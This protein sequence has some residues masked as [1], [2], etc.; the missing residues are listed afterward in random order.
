M[1]FNFRI[2][3]I[4]GVA[5]CAVATPAF[6]A[7]ASKP[8]PLADQ[9]SSEA[10]RA[11]SANDKQSPTAA[12]PGIAEGSD[13]VVTATLANEAAPVTASLK[14]TQPQSIISRS[15]IEE[16]LPAL[17]D[18]NQIALISP[19]FTNSGGTNGVGLSESKGQLR[20]FQDAEYNITYDGVP[21]GDTNDPSHHSNTFF[22]SNTIET[23]VVNRGP[24]NASNLGQATFGGSVDLFSRA[25]RQQR[26][27]EG[28]AT[29]GSFNTYLVRALG[30]SG[31]IDA[32]GGTEIVLS[33]Q[34]IN[35]DGARSL[36]PYT[37]SNVFGKIFIPISNDVKLSILG[38]YSYNRFRQP[39]ND[40]ITIA[41]FTTFGKTFSLNNDPNSQ[42]YTFYNPE[43]KK[44]DFE[45]VKLEAN[46]AP[47]S[48]FENRGYTYA[49]ENETL[50]G[51]TPTL[52]G[53]PTEQ[54][55]N[56][57]RLTPAGGLVFGVPGYT[58]TNLYRVWGDIAKVKVDF[59]FG[60]LTA[61]IWFEFAN[62]YR[63]QRDVNLVTL[64][65]NFIGSISTNV[66]GANQ[67]QTPRN[68][69]FDQKSRTNQAEEFVELELRPLPGLTIT[70]GFKHL[71]FTRKID[72]LFNQTS[73]IATNSSRS[74]TADL[75]FAT[76]NYSLTRNLSAYFQ[77]AQ[78]FLAPPLSQLYIVN[79]AF[80]SAEPQRST[81]YQVGVV[82]HGSHVSADFDLYQIDFNNRFT[83][84]F[85]ATLGTTVFFNQG[86]AQYKGIEGEV[87]YAFDNGLAVF[88]NGSL[89]SARTAN[90]TAAAPVIETYIARAPKT[91]AAT[92]ILYKHGPIRF[93]LI[94]KYTGVQ[95][96]DSGNTL[97][98]GGYNTAIIAASYDIGPFRLGIDATNITDSQKVTQISGT[99]VA[100]R[101]Y[102]FQAPQQ[103]TG[104]IGVRF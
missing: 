14:T 52:A 25:T 82:Y 37:A 66:N 85:D 79:P 87:T 19:S 62:T 78:G 46:I 32:L 72:A 70:P 33:A 40:G 69:R 3:L 104:T 39:D 45:I 77:Y 83:S 31:A 91:T 27:I 12:K 96:A 17:A 73:R 10:G 41:Q 16:S 11:T 38:T 97:R 102:F 48:V 6:A 57:V 5:A 76:V 15:F 56:T 65:P 35:T 29:Y 89:N 92:G 86:G 74:Y 28:L 8:A 24:G 34:H 88:I 103:I 59:G 55:A 75:P 51:A 9:P 54:A 47:K 68:I 64:A 13:I 94:D 44:T 22:P 21:F 7:A 98:L 20:G 84:V 23:E 1:R 42:A 36:S 50:S 30:Q 60:A 26:G 61:G 4:V 99:A 81:N 2:H 93:S 43:S 63:Q 49:Y 71:D 95:Y 101:Q 90:S 53:L 100:T 58:K 67:S 18:F 80:S